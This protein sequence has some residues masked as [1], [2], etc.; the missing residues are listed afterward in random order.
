MRDSAGKWLLNGRH[1]DDTLIGGE[2]DDYLAG[3]KGNDSYVISTGDG[4][5]I[6]LCPGTRHTDKSPEE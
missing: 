2:G 3:N 6:Y 4:S 5:D 1:G